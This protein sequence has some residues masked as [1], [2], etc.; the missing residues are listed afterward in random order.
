[1]LNIFF[2]YIRVLK[3]TRDIK[4]GEIIFEEPP[5]FAGPSKSSKP[6]CLVC[7]NEVRQVRS[8]IFDQYISVICMLY[9]LGKFII[10]YINLQIGPNTLNEVNNVWCERCDFPMC[11]SECSAAHIN[12]PECSIISRHK[13]MKINKGRFASYDHQY[14]YE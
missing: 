10:S 14:I 8:T 1:M 2:I 11:S 5:V 4:A 6:I 7:L 13:P 12:M 3:A 9:I